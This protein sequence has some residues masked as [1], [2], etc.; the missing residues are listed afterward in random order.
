MAGLS[1]MLLALCLDGQIP[2]IKKLWT[3]SFAMLTSGF[4]ML[5]LSLLMIVVDQFGWKRWA[6]PIRVF[7]TNAIVAYVGAWIIAIVLDV[8]GIG[9]K[10]THWLSTLI[11]DPYLMSATYAF[12][13]LCLIWLLLL[14]FYLKRWFIKV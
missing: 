10:I 4:A 7:G 11:S 9:W 8:T 5:I 3:S 2:I 14:P 6:M 13:F 12:G 1:L